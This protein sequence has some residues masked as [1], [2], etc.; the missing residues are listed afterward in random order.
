MTKFH[1]NQKM[2]LKMTMMSLAI[3]LVII[4]QTRV[5]TATVSPVERESPLRHIHD[6][7]EWNKIVRNRKFLTQK[8]R[9]DLATQKRQ[10]QLQQRYGYDT[11]QDSNDDQ[12]RQLSPLVAGARTLNVIICLM[13]W[14]N[15]GTR[16]TLPVSDVQALFNG[17]GR[18]PKWP[19]GTVNDFL[20]ETSYGQ[21]KLNAHVHNWVKTTFSEQHFTADGS[22][23]RG[24]EIQEAFQPVLKSLE[25]SGVDLSQYDTDG[26]NEID[27]TIF[28]HSGYDGV[29]PGDDCYTGNYKFRGSHRT[30]ISFC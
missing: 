22:Q 29:N 10:H 26:D 11:I 5:V 8:G 19:G 24:Q 21:F 16:N 13:Q 14:S 20:E 12:S 30:V 4:T 9:D 15:H 23:G 1:C 2:I 3:V 28:L 27:L 6:E 7:D 18:D 17:S 25:G